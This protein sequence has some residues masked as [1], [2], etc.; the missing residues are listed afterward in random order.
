MIASAGFFHYRAGERSDLSLDI[1]PS[2]PIA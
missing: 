1:E 2:L